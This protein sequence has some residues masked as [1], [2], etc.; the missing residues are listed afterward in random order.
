MFQ[1]C[2]FK[3]RGVLQNVW[4]K[5]TKN[6]DTLTLWG[7]IWNKFF[8]ENSILHSYYYSAITVIYL[9]A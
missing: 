4:E 7:I 8:M 6:S 1:I 3:E 9:V 2:K 5:K